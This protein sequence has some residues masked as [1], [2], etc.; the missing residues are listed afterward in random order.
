MIFIQMN[1]KIQMIIKDSNLAIKIVVITRDIPQDHNLVGIHQT[2]MKQNKQYLSNSIEVNQAR[3][4]VRTIKLEFHNKSISRI[5][6]KLSREVVKVTP[7]N[8]NRTNNKKKP[9]Y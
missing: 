3:W 5:L 2:I 1:H 9:N 7:N 6:M 4:V 8:S